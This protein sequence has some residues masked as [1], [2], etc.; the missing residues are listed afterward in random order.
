M[1]KKFLI[2][3]DLY[4]FLL[5]TTAKNSK[6]NESSIQINPGKKGPKKL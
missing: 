1:E 6:L 5:E 2:Q 4:V 3:N